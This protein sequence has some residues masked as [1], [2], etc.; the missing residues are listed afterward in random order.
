MVFDLR[1]CDNWVSFIRYLQDISKQTLDL[2]IESCHTLY[3]ELEQILRHQKS[4]MGV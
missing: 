2:C 4:K 3:K 1:I